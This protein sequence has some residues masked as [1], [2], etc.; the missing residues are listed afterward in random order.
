[1]IRGK[2]CGAGSPRPAANPHPF[3]APPTKMLPAVHAFPV[4][5][6]QKPQVFRE[7]GP[8]LRDAA[9]AATGLILAQEPQNRGRNREDGAK[10]CHRRIRKHAH[11]VPS[12]LSCLFIPGHRPRRNKPGESNSQSG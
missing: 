11:Y 1:M 10:E 7:H 5:A 12:E 9:D 2:L 6:N 8:R 3:S 4:L